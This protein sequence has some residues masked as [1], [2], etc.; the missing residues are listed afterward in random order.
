V[1]AK[2]IL[3]P[4]ELQSMSSKDLEKVFCQIRKYGK[5]REVVEG[6]Y[7][8]KISRDPRQNMYRIE[9]SCEPGDPTVA[10]I[11]AIPMENCIDLSNSNFDY[12]LFIEVA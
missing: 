4:E 5:I 7:D 2:H 6:I 8:V 3:K 9:W 1:K 12:T 10:S 11:P